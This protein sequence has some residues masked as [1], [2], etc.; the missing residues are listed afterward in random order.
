MSPI[1]L[2]RASSFPLSSRVGAVDGVDLAQGVETMGS[3]QDVKEVTPYGYGG[4][5]FHV[6]DFT[7]RLSR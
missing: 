1:L 5:T 7:Y 6:S 3:A 4:L 2:L